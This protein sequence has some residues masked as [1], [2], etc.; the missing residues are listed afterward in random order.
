MS[1]LHFSLSLSFP[2]LS[3]SNYVLVFLF[4]E[5]Y[6]HRLQIDMRQKKE[7]KQLIQII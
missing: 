3:F 6:K 7:E 4:Q 1:F 5:C 2:F